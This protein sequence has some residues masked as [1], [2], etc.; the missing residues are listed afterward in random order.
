MK[1]R[2]SIHRLESVPNAHCPLAAV[3]PRSRVQE[4]GPRPGAL[5]RRSERGVSL[6]IILALLAG[7][8][9]IVAAN[10]TAVA[11]LKQELKLIDQRQLKKYGQGL[12]H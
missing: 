10:S 2:R 12:G 11:L 6:L 8:A 3:G 5:A 1:T 9:I 7:M 4:A